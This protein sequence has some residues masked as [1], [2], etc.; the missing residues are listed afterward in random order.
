MSN[1]PSNKENSSQKMLII[2]AV[3]GAAAVAA[4]AFG[5]HSLRAILSETQLQ[6]FQTGVTYQFYHI[7]AM[8]IVLVWQNAHPDK[9]LRLSF[10]LFFSG[11]LL[12][13]GS[14]YL[15]STAEITGLKLKSFIGPLTPAGGLFFIA[16][17]INLIRVKI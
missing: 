8:A 17:W 11:I 7:L 12:F 10:Y 3:T 2:L 6:T 4:G 13:S 16:G 5:S 14:L 9:V 1:L 15:L